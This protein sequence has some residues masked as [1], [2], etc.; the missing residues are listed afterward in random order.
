MF[1]S[2]AAREQN[3]E[4]SA[5]KDRAAAIFG[6]KTFVTAIFAKHVIMMRASFGRC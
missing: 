4:R 1:V 3:E 2:K 5:A 6:K